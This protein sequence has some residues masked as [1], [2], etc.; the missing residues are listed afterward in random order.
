MKTG[1]FRRALSAA[2]AVLAFAA[3]PAWAQDPA[4]AVYR[5]AKI[6]TVDPETTWAE[7][8]AIRDGRFVYVGDDKGVDV[9]IGPETEVTDLDGRMVMP[10]IHDAHQHMVLAQARNIYCQISPE[11]DIDALIA[12]LRA[13][14]EEKRPD[15]WIIADVYR[16]DNF[17]GGKADRKFLDEAFPDTPVYIREWSYHHALVNTKALEIAGIDRDTPDPDGGTILH[18]EDG[19]PS[20]ELLAG[21][22]FLAARHLPPLSD[23]AIRKALLDTAALCA[24]YGIT[25]VQDAG[26][27]DA[28]ARQLHE[29]DVS[30]QWNL[31]TL[32]HVFWGNP[33]VSMMSIDQSEEVLAHRAEL[34]SPRV[35]LDAVKLLIDGSP[36]QPHHTDV[37]L[38]GHGHYDRAKLYT[39]PETIAAAL[40]RFEEEN[41][42]V[43]MH[44][45]GTGANR[46]AVNAIEAMRKV[47]RQPHIKPEIAHSLYFSEEDMD[48]LAPL[49]IVTEMSPAIWQIKG[50]LT[51]SLKGAW[52]FRSLLSR[53]VTMTIGSDWVVLPSPNLFPAIGGMLDHG[54]ESITI[55]DAIRI[56]TRNGAEVAGWADVTGSIEVGKMADMIVLDRNLFDAA[57]AEIG[58]TRVLRTVFEGRTIY[59]AE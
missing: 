5:D 22:T 54:D 9:F 2:A 14:P 11:A 40:T 29:L 35:S 20:G 31:R 21:A 44:A 42:R 23:E 28:V 7:A 17:P 36:L 48:R 18:R 25:S 12:G 30:G 15:G 50:P 39:T 49:G 58:E 13:C 24:Q 45:V 16:G 59:T 3:S 4:D 57:A 51:E 10:G 32:A 19:E 6:Y 46:V 52:P 27:T 34:R 37:Q 47:N 53:G 8:V 38:D 1:S 55:A 26:V 56:A 43:K 33:A 41:L